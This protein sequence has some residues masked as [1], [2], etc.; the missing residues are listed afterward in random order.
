VVYLGGQ[1]IEIDLDVLLEAILVG[2]RGEGRRRGLQH[3]S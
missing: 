1:A 3:R 2:G